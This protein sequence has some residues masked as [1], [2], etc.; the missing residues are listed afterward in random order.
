LVISTGLA[1]LA[2]L[3]SWALSTG[4]LSGRG[5]QTTVQETRGTPAL[6]QSAPK[7]T[8]PLPYSSPNP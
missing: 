2:L 6:E 5:G 3:G 4:N 7:T 8:D 1:A